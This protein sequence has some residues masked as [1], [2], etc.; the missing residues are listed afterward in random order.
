MSLFQRL[1]RILPARSRPAS[2]VRVVTDSTADLPADVA[3]EQEIAV[4]PLQVMFGEESFRDGVNLTSEEFFRRLQEADELP[5]TSQ[6]S[7]GEFQQTY[8]QVAE[9]TDRIL[10]IH[11][12]SGF[13]GTAEA[14]RQAAQALTDRCHIEVVDSGTV[15]MAMGFGVLAA[16]RAAR[17]GAD[18]ETCAEA[19][20]SVF[21]RQRIAIAFDTLE[22]LRRGGRIGRAQAF[23][24]SLLRLKPILT[25]R[26]GEAQPLKRARTRRKAL[27][28]LVSL[29]LEQGDVVE[30]AVMYTTSEDEA[31]SLAEEV[32]ARFP[33]APVHTGNMGPVIG[34]HGGP[35]VIAIV[36]V[37]AEPERAEDTDAGLAAAGEDQT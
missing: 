25:I 10:S 5:R 33:N 37:L 2:P 3:R 29:C 8:E 23:L 31:R 28:E 24:G 32:A 7:V 34:V 18:I 35:G 19:A 26:D 1:R 9:E 11:L 12:S 13:S 17:D 4:V 22:Y 20:R 15:S 14:A 36:A 16:A 21:G 6:P 30:A 27:Q